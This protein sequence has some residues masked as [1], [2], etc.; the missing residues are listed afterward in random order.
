[1]RDFFNILVFLLDR[2]IIVQLVLLLTAHQTQHMQCIFI[3]MKTNDSTTA[4]EHERY[5]L[6]WSH[7]GWG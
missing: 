5:K 4:E 7:A 2:P 1:M 3:V 6:Y